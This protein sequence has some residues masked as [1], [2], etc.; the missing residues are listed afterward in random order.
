MQI[1]HFIGGPLNRRAVKLCQLRN[2]VFTDKFGK[3]LEWQPSSSVTHCY[4]L[5]SIVTV[6]GRR[7]NLALF[8]GRNG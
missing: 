4:E 6:T 5:H 7:F 3:T 2:E 1:V 8:D